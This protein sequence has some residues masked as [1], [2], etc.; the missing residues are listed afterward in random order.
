AGRRARAGPRRPAPA[1]PSRARPGSL[2]RPAGPRRP[3]PGSPSRRPAGPASPPPPRARTSR[4]RPSAGPRAWRRTSR[5]RRGT[6]PPRTLTPPPPPGAPPGLTLRPFRGLR[7]SAD[8]VEDLGAVT[9]PPY[10]VLDPDAVLA[11]ESAEPHNVVRLILPR[12]EESGPEG[13]YE[14]AAR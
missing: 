3:A 4:T 10:D 12:E 6:A 14:H 8:A 13:R 7:Y 2:P 5:T 11:L 9:S 1:A